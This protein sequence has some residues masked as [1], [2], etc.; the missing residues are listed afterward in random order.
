MLLSLRNGEQIRD[1]A[2]ELALER[3]IPLVNLNLSLERI[4]FDVRRTSNMRYAEHE[5]TCDGKQLGWF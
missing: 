5:D 3:S 1:A 4:D 2:L